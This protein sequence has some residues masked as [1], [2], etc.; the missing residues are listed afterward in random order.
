M[1]RW[2]WVIFAFEIIW[3]TLSPP[4]FK[5]MILRYS[6]HSSPNLASITLVS[7]GARR[8]KIR[9]ANIWQKPMA[10][11]SQRPERFT[12]SSFAKNKKIPDGCGDH[13]HLSEGINNDFS[14]SFFPG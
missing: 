13:H 4:S 10:N 8:I 12:E 7:F 1:E 14:P 11:G 9:G 6:A 5:N 2:D 3:E